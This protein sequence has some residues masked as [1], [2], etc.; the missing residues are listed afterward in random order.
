MPNPWTVLGI[1]QTASADEIK[2][3]Y[4]R[5]AKDHHP[6]KGGDPDRFMEIQNA[7]QQLTNPQKNQTH[8]QNSH[9]FSNFNEQDFFKEIFE[10]FSTQGFGYRPANP[11]FEAAIMITVAEHI[12][13]CTKTIEIDDNGKTRTVNITIPPGSQTGDAV[14]YS[15]QGSTINPKLPPGDLY[16]RIR[17]QPYDNFELRNGDLY[18]EKTLSVVDAWIGCSV[19]VRDPFGSNL[20]IRVPDAC[21]PGTILRVKGQGG[22]NRV[23]RQRGDMMIKIHIELPKLTDDQKEQLKSILS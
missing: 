18:A 11:N 7:Y 2:A 22:F 12:Q 1:D 3:A 9:P 19:A 10:K 14:K 16:V 20:E 6:D 21:Q 13:G 23:S 4:R 5:L 15:G 8:S 17:V